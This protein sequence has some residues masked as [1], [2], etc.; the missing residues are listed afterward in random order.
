MVDASSPKYGVSPP[1]GGGLERLLTLPRP[2]C[3]RFLRNRLEASLVVK[4]ARA[5]IALDQLLAAASAERQR[6]E[7]L[8]HA[9]AQLC[10]CLPTSSWGRGANA[11]LPIA[12]QARRGSAQVGAV[13]CSRLTATIQLL[14]LLWAQLQQWA[15]MNASVAAELA[16]DHVQ[17]ATQKRIVAEAEQ[18]LAGKVGA[19][20]ACLPKAL[21]SA[22][23]P[24]SSLT[25]FSAHWAVLGTH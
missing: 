18:Q 6:S 20:L 9:A 4:L 10:R 7:A 23:A 13:L 2:W 25:L 5:G 24:D 14:H 12:A 21:P 16:A 3:S 15:A 1:Q 22:A 19:L 17:I 8:E 11:A